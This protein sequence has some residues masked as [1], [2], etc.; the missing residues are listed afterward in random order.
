MLRRLLAG[1]AM[2]TF[3]A[4][5]T[6]G[7]AASADTFVTAPMTASPNPGI[8]GQWIVFRIQIGNWCA[9]GGRA[10]FLYANNQQ[11]GT[12]YLPR[13][14]TVA[15]G[16]TYTRLGVGT[17]AMYASTPWCYPNPGQIVS[18]TTDTIIVS[19]KAKP[20]AA[21]PVQQ[22]PPKASAP[23]I[24]TTVE[25][26]AATSASGVQKSMSRLTATQFST[27]L[28]AS[29][30]PPPHQGLDHVIWPAAVALFA[31]LLVALA[32]RHRSRPIRR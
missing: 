2:A 7:V 23:P 21:P 20:S 30:S 5:A 11:V 6:G 10:F 27:R 28:A 14:G 17:Y 26:E 29:P 22:S 31:C 15:T 16:G 19:V 24:S 32:I 4:V 25:R 1:A 12:I 9:S 18:I 13:S 3:L 8:S